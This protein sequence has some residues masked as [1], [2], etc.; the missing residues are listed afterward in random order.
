MRRTFSLD[1]GISRLNRAKLSGSQKLPCDRLGLK[2]PVDVVGTFMQGMQ[3]LQW[4]A[5]YPDVVDH[6][7]ALKAL[8]KTAPWAAAA[9][10]RVC[11]AG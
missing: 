9:T 2:G 11:S 8:A 1:W 10:S 3:T 5:D 7:V 6:L 4:A